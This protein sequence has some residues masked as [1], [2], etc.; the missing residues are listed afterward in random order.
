MQ[1]VSSKDGRRKKKLQEKYMHLRPLLFGCVV[2]SGVFDFLEM[3]SWKK[4]RNSER[5]TDLFGEARSDFHRHGRG[6]WA[7]TLR[8]SQFWMWDPLIFFVGHEHRMHNLESG[9]SVYPNVSD[10]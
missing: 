8:A 9:S 6:A 7:R 3:E 2:F 1:R 4:R 5:R 10:T